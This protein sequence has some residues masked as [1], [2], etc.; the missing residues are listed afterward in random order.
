MVLKQE[1][2]DPFPEWPGAGLGFSKDTI[3]IGTLKL[4]VAKR[5]QASCPTI[6]NPEPKAADGKFTATHISPQSP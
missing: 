1:K 3:L 4:S 2:Q 5:F 6:G